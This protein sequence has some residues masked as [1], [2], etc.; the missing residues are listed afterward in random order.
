MVSN[1]NDGF[2]DLRD[3]WIDLAYALTALKVDRDEA[4]GRALR[5]SD[6]SAIEAAYVGV[7]SA[8]VRLRTLVGNAAGTLA[9][10]LN[11]VGIRTP[12]I[13]RLAGAFWESTSNSVDDLVSDAAGALQSTW[14]AIKGLERG[15]PLD[16]VGRSVATETS[17]RGDNERRGRKRRKDSLRGRV[18][19][20]LIDS[21]PEWVPGEDL[22]SW[23]QP[24][25][26]LDGVP[27]PVQLASTLV[28]E[29][30]EAFLSRR[31]ADGGV[32]Y[33]ATPLAT[34]YTD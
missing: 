23:A 16:E 5:T 32:E 21:R 33:L 26:G 6:T 34:K 15:E 4:P 8:Q 9:S 11:D 19:N 12:A 27:S 29:Q 25:W 28:L 2:Q 10:A 3:A 22:K 24:G 30:P 17:T 1:P 7:S 13:A 14:R 31:L 18:A 20:A